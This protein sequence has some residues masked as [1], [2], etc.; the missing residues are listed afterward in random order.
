M[1]EADWSYR[2]DIFLN[3]F[4]GCSRALDVG[5][6]LPAWIEE[7]YCSSEFPLIDDIIS[8]YGLRPDDT[9][10]LLALIWA[11]DC[12]LGRTK[13]PPSAKTR[14]RQN[15]RIIREIEALLRSLDGFGEG[16]AFEQH[17]S[18]FKTS[19]GGSDFTVDLSPA[20]NVS[21]QLRQLK[22]ILVKSE[23]HESS[24][25]KQSFPSAAME[26]LG[27]IIG[28][29]LGASSNP[30]FT[31]LCDELFGPVLIRNGLHSRAALSDVDEPPRLRDSAQRIRKKRNDVTLSGRRS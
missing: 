27:K 14:K 21:K 22:S 12:C 5:T 2:Y 8:R 18:H 30:N 9:T 1:V 16:P 20:Q 24:G 4:I 23:I 31:G 6:K 13:K 28:D 7:Q 19:L 17:V 25:P 15:S 29:R 10:Y 11:L 26:A 3:H